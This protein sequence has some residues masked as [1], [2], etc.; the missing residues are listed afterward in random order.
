MRHHELLAL[1]IFSSR[2]RLGDRIDLLLRRGRTFSPRVSAV[3]VAMSV[4]ALFGSVV[5]GSLA[6]RL[7]AFHLLP[8]FDAASIRPNN[9]PRGGKGGPRGFDLRFEP[10]RL[11]EPSPPGTLF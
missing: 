3:R 7:L 4:V 10:G 1:G 6:P 9:T 8:A 2:S 5:A 11:W